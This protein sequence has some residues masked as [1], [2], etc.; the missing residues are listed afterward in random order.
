MEWWDEAKLFR[1][2]H[3]EMLAKPICR[4]LQ[5]W[6]NPL[7]EVKIK[8]KII[9]NLYK[10]IYC[11]QGPYVISPAALKATASPRLIELAVP[12]REIPEQEINYSLKDKIK[13]KMDMERINILAKPREYTNL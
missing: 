5:I 9:K 7:L 4:R 3:L 11:T 8:M 10:R 12:K 6:P 1:L 2:V 13:Y